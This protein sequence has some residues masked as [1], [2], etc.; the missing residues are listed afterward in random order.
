MV[1]FISFEAFLARLG[2]VATRGTQ[3]RQLGAAKKSLNDETPTPLFTDAVPLKDD[4]NEELVEQLNHTMHSVVDSPLEW[5]AI[6]RVV[7]HDIFVSPPTTSNA[8][9]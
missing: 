3:V 4:W 5:K 6:E 1:G 9:C 7:Q 2:A 8:T